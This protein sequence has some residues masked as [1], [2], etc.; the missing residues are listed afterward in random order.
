VESLVAALAEAAGQRL[1]PEAAAIALAEPIGR[2]RGA[3]AQLQRMLNVE[4]YPVLTIDVDGST[5]VLSE[6][7]LREQFAQSG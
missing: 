3:I 1:A 7:L 4:G 6:A 5:L 2:L